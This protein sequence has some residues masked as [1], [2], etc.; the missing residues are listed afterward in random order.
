MKGVEDHRNNTLVI[1]GVDGI[2]R[3]TRRRPAPSADFQ[4][5]PRNDES[6]EDTMLHNDKGE[7]DQPI[8]DLLQGLD[9]M[10]VNDDKMPENRWR[11]L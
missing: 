6:G 7:A 10:D 1:E 4:I 11:R 8:Y 3:Q 5:I 9:K 2:P